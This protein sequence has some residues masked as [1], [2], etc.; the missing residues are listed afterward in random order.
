MKRRKF[1]QSTALAGAGTLLIPSC[2][3]S[4]GS[5]VPEFLKDH[6]EAWLEDPRKATL[7]WFR[8]ARFGLFMHYGLYSL[9]GRHEWVQYREKIPVSEYGKLIDQFTAERFDAD[10]ITDLALEAEMKYINIT[11]RHHDSFCLWDTEYSDFKSTNSPARRDLLAELSEQCNKKGLGFFLYYSHGRD[12]RHPHAPN[13]DKWPRAA[14]PDYDP[15]DPNYKYGDKHD[16]DIYI[17]FMNNQI[18][19]LLEMFT[20]LAGIWLDGIATPRSGDFTLFRC[21]DLYDMI[22]SKQPQVLVSYKQGLLGTEDFMAPE[23][24]WT[25]NADKPLE[26]CDTLQ[27]RGW[28]YIKEDDGKHKTRKEV[29]EM[30]RTA[31]DYPANLLLNTGPLPSG[32]IHPEDVRVLRAVGEEIRTSGWE[33]I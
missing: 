28:G 24:H 14:R 12:W 3:G 25:G 5:R 17:E 11:S 13:N 1:I 19:E 27:P 8:Q 31:A 9:L 4:G 15:P 21:Q 33:G 30:L 2:T 6:K 20:P 22:H 23:R 7:E 26:I 29:L 10:F 16:L 18:S 32:E